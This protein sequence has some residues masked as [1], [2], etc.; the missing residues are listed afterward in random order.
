LWVFILAFYGMTVAA[1]GGNLP[2]ALRAR[3]LSVQAMNTADP[4]PS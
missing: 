3:A 2:P 1:F 4:P